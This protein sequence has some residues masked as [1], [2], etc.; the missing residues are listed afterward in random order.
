MKNFAVT[1]FRIHLP[2][3]VLTIAMLGIVL[4]SCKAEVNIVVDEDGAG[5]IEII[6]A[7]S[8][9]ILSLMRIGGE[10]PFE[11]LLE[12]PEGELGSEGLE[13]SSIEAYSQGGYTG[14]RI[15]AD[16]DAYDPTI[17]AISQADSLLGGMTDALG[18][19]DFEFART[20]EDDG[21]IVE[22]NQTTDSSITDGF[23]E[24]MGDTPF[25]LGELDLPFVFSLQLPG[26]YVEHNADREVDGVL[27]WDANLLEGI[28]VLVVS[29]DP[30]LQFEVVPIVI[31]VLFILIFGGIVISVVVSRER[32]RRRLEQDAAIEAAALE[33]RQS[34]SDQAN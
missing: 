16:F 22:L 6:G 31:T 34:A 29:R 15:K 1:N 24:F 28:D 23:D 26:E 14:V 20:A 13:G 19:G 17:A 21:W 4:T 27:I 30:G 10:D 25:D 11:D 2:V 5:E 7:V 8:D 18:I 32:R 9:A 3:L 12:L 33:V